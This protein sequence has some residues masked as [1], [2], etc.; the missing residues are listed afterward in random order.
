M[1]KAMLEATPRACVGKPVEDIDK[2]LIE[3]CTI[4]QEC[5]TAFGQRVSAMDDLDADFSSEEE[6]AGLWA[7]A[8][9]LRAEWR[10]IAWG[11]IETP[12]HNLTGRQAKVDALDAYLLH[13]GAAIECIGLDL[14]RSLVSDLKRTRDRDAAPYPSASAGMN[15]STLT[16]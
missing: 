4:F 1:L 5:V 12:A 9:Q 7:I 10:S 14:A 11:I 8:R 16:G 15:A 3:A 6:L 13:G 2:H